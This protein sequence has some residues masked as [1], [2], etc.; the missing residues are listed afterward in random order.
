MEHDVYMGVKMANERLNGAQ[1]LP[2]RTGLRR[3]RSSF[4]CDL[5]HCTSFEMEGQSRGDRLVFVQG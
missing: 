5:Q 1:R 4:S 3:R 2:V